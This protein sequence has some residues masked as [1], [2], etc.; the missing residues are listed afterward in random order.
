MIHWLRR[1]AW[2]GWWWAS[3]CSGHSGQLSYD[4][5]CPRC[6]AGGWTNVNSPRF[7]GK[8][9]DRRR[10]GDYWRWERGDYGDE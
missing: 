5:D 7:F 1:R 6:T 8:W 10:F 3:F 4:P 9:R 2:F